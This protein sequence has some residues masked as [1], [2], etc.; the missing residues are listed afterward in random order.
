[1]D[2]RG[3]QAAAGL[4]D[5]AVNVTLL[6]FSLSGTIDGDAFSMQGR[7]VYDNT[8]ASGAAYYRSRGPDEDE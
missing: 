5:Q 3:L 1:L 2:I 4:T 8:E 7:I 6:D